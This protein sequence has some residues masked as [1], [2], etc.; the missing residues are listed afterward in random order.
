MKKSLTVVFD[1]LD[2]QRFIGNYRKLMVNYGL[3]PDAQ[4]QFSNV[5][6]ISVLQA[7]WLINPSILME[8]LMKSVSPVSSVIEYCFE[9]LR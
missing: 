1:Y 4:D 3:R 2:Y 6:P 7:D 8:A 5:I 9:K